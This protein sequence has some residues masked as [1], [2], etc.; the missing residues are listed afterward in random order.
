[1]A[2]ET[3][4]QSRSRASFANLPVEILARILGYCDWDTAKVFVQLSRKAFTSGL[5]RVRT[6][7]RIRGPLV[8]SS[9]LCSTIL[10]D[11]SHLTLSYAK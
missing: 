1:M 2:P 7:A 11:P 3:Q 4:L 9:R 8:K 6:V 10:R 5:P